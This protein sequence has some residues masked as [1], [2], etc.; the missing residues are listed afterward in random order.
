MPQQRRCFVNG[1]NGNPLKLSRIRINVWQSLD[2]K[3]KKS[4]KISAVQDRI[5]LNHLQHHSPNNIYSNKQMF[6]SK[7]TNSARK[8]NTKNTKH[9]WLFPSI[10]F[11]N[12]HQCR[13]RSLHGRDVSR[14]APW[15]F[16]SNGVWECWVVNRFLDTPKMEFKGFFPCIFPSQCYVFPYKKIEGLGRW[17][18][19]NDDY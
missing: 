19:D 12:P 18:R 4:L 9:I 14:A 2:V 15:R 3:W 7:T 17:L 5:H 1:N 8:K 6:L 16:K 10:S 13:L 11:N